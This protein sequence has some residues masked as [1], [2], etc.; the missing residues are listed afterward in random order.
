MPARDE[1]RDL[2][3]TCIDAVLDF[4]A[5]PRNVEE[6]PVVVASKR[7][8]G[9][10]GSESG[11]ARLTCRSIVIPILSIGDVECLVGGDSGISRSSESPWRVIGKGRWLR[12]VVRIIELAEHLIREHP[13]AKA[14]LIESVVSVSTELE[15]KIELK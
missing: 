13:A 5:F 4:A 8:E 12:R 9:K 3:A 2:G 7:R 14:L 6:P 1:T 15:D 11:L 10:S